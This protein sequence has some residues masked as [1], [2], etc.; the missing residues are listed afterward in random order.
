VWVWI[1][2]KFV[3]SIVLQ[4][5]MSTSDSQ[6]DLLASEELVAYL[7]GE[8][9]Q[10]ESR[11]VEERLASDADYRQ[12]LRDLDQAWEALDALPATKVDDNFARTTIEMVTLAAQRDIDQGS[13]QAATAKRKR[14][15]WWLAA[16]AAL[17]GVAFAAT[18][19]FL[20]NPNDDLVANLPVIQQFDVLNRIENAEFLRTL[21]QQVPFEK[22]APDPVLVDRELTTWKTIS[23]SSPR[24]R[25]K[26]LEKLTPQ[27]KADLSERVNRFNELA[28]SPEKQTR[29]QQMREL[30][31]TIRQAGEGEE[32]QRTLL[33]YGS[34]LSKRQ[35]AEQED[36]R[37]LPADER[38]ALIKRYVRDDEQRALRHLS[39]EDAAR[40]RAEI[41]AIYEDRKWDFER[42]NRR[43]DDDNRI[44]LDGPPWLRA[45]M[46]VHW[47]LWND[48]QDGKTTT[49][50][51]NQLS[52][53]QQAYWKK[54]PRRGGPP[55]Q[56]NQRWQ[57][58][59]WIRE[60]IRPRWGPEELEKYF[61]EKLDNQ[62]RERLL[63]LPS[64]QMQAQLER[65]YIGYLSGLSGSEQWIGGF[66]PGGEMPP[67]PPPGAGGPGRRRDGRSRDRDRRG[68]NRDDDDNDRDRRNNDRDERDGPRG[69]SNPGSPP[70]REHGDR[71]PPPQD[72]GQ[73]SPPSPDG[74]PPRP[75]G[76]PNG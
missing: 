30:E 1:E 34:W 70:S 75:D 19:K 12:Q 55:N 43:R 54:L 22:L 5:N 48:E 64:D 8:L 6:A 9:S 74:P 44:R 11:R 52:A 72:S 50:L 69:E 15:A 36:L 32:L 13:A 42:A 56:P 68:G 25:R 40:L 23:E 29:L 62:Q 14:T 67:G 35:P 65:M 53:E 76:S 61:T 31:R 47:E 46:V 38:I 51:I 71:Q 2:K 73:V 37:V 27:E 28:K 66:G 17:A 20:P 49:R 60:S 58:V 41:L 4:R 57:L 7:D 3:T 59:Q 26:W 33:A 10:E 18:L 45:L 63:G 24:E 39:E 21:A 16:G